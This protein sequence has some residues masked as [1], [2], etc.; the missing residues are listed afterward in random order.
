MT[1]ITRRF[2]R[3]DKCQ[4]EEPVGQPGQD[5]WVTRWESARERPPYG[6]EAH[7]C[8]TCTHPA[9]SLFGEPA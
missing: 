5:R 7:T 8:P 3:C 2:V 1:V 9:P 6:G 4:R